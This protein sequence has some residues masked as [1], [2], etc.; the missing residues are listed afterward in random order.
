MSVQKVLQAVLK[1]VTTHLEAI[2][3]PVMLA[4]VLKMTTAL[5]LVST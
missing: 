5:V 3:V 1:S 2:F 4:I